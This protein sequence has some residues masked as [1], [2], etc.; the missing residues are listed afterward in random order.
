M[1][2]CVHKAGDGG[3]AWWRI[4]QPYTWI[5]ENTD[6]EVFIYDPMVHSPARLRDEQEAAD[7]LVYQMGFGEFI[8]NIVVANKERANPKKIVLEY[9]DNI[10]SVHP[11]NV[12]YKNFASEE[13]NMTFTDDKTAEYFTNFLRE[14]KSE[15]KI[16]QNADGSWTVEMWK[17][18]V[19]GFDTKAN[20]IRAAATAEA[21]SMCDML[22]VTNPELG[23]QFRQVRPTGTIAVIP[24]CI[25]LERWLPMKENDSE[26]I[27]IG[28]SG[29]SA[30]FQDIHLIRKAL[31]RIFDKY[32]AV[33][34]VMQ[35]VGFTSLFQPCKDNNYKDYT[36]RVEWRAWHTDNRTYPLDVR[37]LKCDIGICPVIDDSFNRGKSE[38]KWIEFSAMKVP[39]VLSPVCYK[40]AVHGKTGLFANS[41]DEWFDCLD[42]LIQSDVLRKKISDA[43]HE[44][45]V[46]DHTLTQY[47]CLY[48]ALNAL[49]DSKVGTGIIKP[50]KL[51]KIYK[52]ELVTA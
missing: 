39:T 6:A 29:G 25:D 21:M 28:W 40:S 31:W 50:Y 22:T 48:N 16:V 38:L 47:K 11:M 42:R 14:T 44:K 3:V 27:R 51:N 26:N 15:K 5:K 19:D 12:A 17:D 49:N 10:F 20:K 52:K 35:G 7:I 37:N 8:R 33:K 30:H 46:V 2:I 4:V 43:A 34:L 1:R 45:I 9:D 32:P 36:D 41:E 23:K 24:N 18:G 13:M